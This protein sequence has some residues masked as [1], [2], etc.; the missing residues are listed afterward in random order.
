MV[1]GKCITPIGT[2]TVAVV[3]LYCCASNLHTVCMVKWKSNE[4]KNA[5]K[6]GIDLKS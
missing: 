6:A 4:G 2:I 1:N 3:L 5:C